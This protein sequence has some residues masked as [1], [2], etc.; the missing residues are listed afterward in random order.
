MQVQLDNWGARASFEQQ[1]NRFRLANKF[2]L[3]APQRRGLGDEI[4]IHKSV[5]LT[6]KGEDMKKC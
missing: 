4:S 1:V 5:E 3:A 6:P 2:R